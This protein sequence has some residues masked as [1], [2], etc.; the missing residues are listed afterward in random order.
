MIKR[1]FNLA[2]RLMATFILFALAA[3]PMAAVAQTQIKLH[4][5]KYKVADDIKVGRQAAAEVEQQMP[6]LRDSAATDYVSRVGHRLVAAIPAEFQHPGFDYYFKLVNA[7]D[8]NAF[9]LPG[10]PMYLNRGMIEAAKNEGEMAGVMAHELSHVALRHG[11][12]QA[13]KAQKYGLLAGILGI[14]GQILG[15]P[16]GAAAQIAGQGVGVYFLKFSREYETE[17]DILGAQIMAR[18]G[19]DPMDLAHMFQT[20]QQQG[21]GSSGGFLSSHPSP[22]NRYARIQQEARLLRVENPVRDSR[23][24]LNVQSRLRGMGRAPSMQ[25]IAQSGQRYPTGENTGNYPSNPPRGRVDY[26]STRYQSYSEFGGAVRISVP[27][28]WRQIGDQNSIWYAPE[29]G[30]GGYQNQN[31]FTHGVNIGVAQT[32]SRNLQQATN[33]FINSLAQGN[34]NLRQRSGLQRSTLSGRTGLSTTLTNVNEATGQRETVT[35]VTTQLRNGQLFYMIA[36]APDNEAG[37]FQ[38]AFRN[39]LRSIQISD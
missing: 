21:G 34:T 8:I 18:A 27:N 10:G 22:A 5:N 6:I 35:V 15:G 7:R 29:G 24:F 1:N 36:V 38:T 14:G 17:A 12:A 19:Y 33:E 16:A 11:T 20:I 39:V 3:M 25:E 2:Q 31:V 37:A 4:S 28:N 32:Q 30:Y 26:P 13:S 9:A 23:E